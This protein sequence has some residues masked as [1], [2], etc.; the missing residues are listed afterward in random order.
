M[1]R[2]EKKTRIISEGYGEMPINPQCM[3]LAEFKHTYFDNWSMPCIIALDSV[4][5]YGEDLS[6][7]KIDI[8]KV[9]MIYKKY[10][11]EVLMSVRHYMSVDK[12]VE[13]LIHERIKMFV[14][15]P[16]MFALRLERFCTI[17]KYPLSIQDLLST[18][19]DSYRV[20]VECF[21]D[22]EKFENDIKENH[23]EVLGKIHTLISQMI[24]R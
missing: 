16:L 15:K 22:K 5:L 6:D 19:D 23:Q 3:T 4:L 2:I 24:E 18:F 1:K 21:I 8:K 7:S 10:M 13:K 11:V 20:L 12:P 9:E 14:L 17:G